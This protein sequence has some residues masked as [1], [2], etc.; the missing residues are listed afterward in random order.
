MDTCP[1]GRQVQVTYNDRRTTVV[2]VGGGIRRYEV[3]GRSVFD[4][5]PINTIFDGGH[6]A[7]LIPWP[8]RLVGR[9]VPLQRR[10]PAACRHRTG[11]RHRL[12]LSRVTPPRGDDAG[13]RLHRPRPGRRRPVPPRAD[14]STNGR[15]L[16]G[17][18]LPG[19]RTLCRATLAAFGHH[20]ESHS[21]WCGDRRNP[22]LVP[23][24]SGLDWVLRE[25]GWGPHKR[26]GRSCRW[27][28]DPKYG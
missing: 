10:K 14:R 6:A 3:G 25:R 9:A 17:E 5:Y 13:L 4:P 19:H 26:A 21:G 2:E 20:Q 18:W 12:R 27:T 1:S 11:R 24:H 15:G 23:H 8:K 22:P 7:P 28:D 16:C